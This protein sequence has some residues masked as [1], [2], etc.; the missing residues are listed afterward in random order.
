M[1]QCCLFEAVQQFN[2]DGSM[3]TSNSAE[4]DSYLVP[5]DSARIELRIVNSRFIGSASYTPSVVAAKDFI[6]QVRAELPGATHHAYAYLIGHG[7]SV[8]AG[9]S[10][11]GEPSGTAG[12]PMLAVL[13]GSGLGDVTAVVTRFFGGTLLGTG[14]LVHAYSDTTREVLAILPHT[15]RVETRTLMIC[16]EYNLY[17]LTHQVLDSH[18]AHI[19]EED[20]GTDV[21]IIFALPV[22]KIGACK[23]EIA[24]ISAGQTEVQE[25]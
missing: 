12:R 1:Q 10:D 22:N 16:T 15:E 23:T 17:A 3:T 8:T 13:R 4:S 24:S 11:A 7:S 2:G 20:F 9:M 19:Q 18:G 25:V 6:A 21:T 14:G 5:A